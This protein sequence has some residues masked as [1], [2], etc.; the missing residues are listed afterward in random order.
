MNAF[1]RFAVTRDQ[2]D[3]VVAQFYAR[4]RRDETLGP[5]FASHITDW[6]PHEEKI[7]R[8]WANAILSERDYHGNPMQAHIAAGNVKE[9]HFAHWLSLFDEVLEQELPRETAQAWSYL[10]HRIGRGLSMG[11]AYNTQQQGA[12][13]KF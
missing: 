12:L 5:I 8:F 7:S 10:A 3:R 9:G 11:L 13:P 6:P 1:A 2:I 4:V